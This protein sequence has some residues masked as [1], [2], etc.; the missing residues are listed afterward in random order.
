[1]WRTV[2]KET[3][4]DKLSIFDLPV[5]YQL[6]FTESISKVFKVN[7]SYYINSTKEK[8]IAYF[9]CYYKYGRIYNPESFS[10]TPLYVFPNVGESIYFEIMESLILILK[11]KFGAIYFKLQPE[12]NDIRPF[13]WH[14]FKIDIRYTHLKNNNIDSHHSV[15]KSLRKCSKQNY[16]YTI[17]TLNE[18]SLELNINTLRNIKI[19]E[20]RIKDTISLLEEWNR[21]GYLKSFNVMSENKLVCSNLI[22]DDAVNKKVYTFLLNKVDTVRYKHAHVFLYQSMIDFYQSQNY[23]E[24]DFCGAN[25]KSISIFK[26]S[27]STQLCTYYNVSY[28]SRIYFIL[29]FLS[30]NFKTFLNKIIR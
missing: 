7:V 1:M 15:A 22:I 21:L 16:F 19:G 28:Y 24:I 27:F 17:A 12:I 18:N 14:N 3:W 5:Y 9:V 23:T 13:L 11:K 8:D 6:S 10:Y 29:N 4:R 26:S 20:K 30:S 2:S 25:I